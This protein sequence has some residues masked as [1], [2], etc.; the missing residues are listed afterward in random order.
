MRFLRTDK[1][2]VNV[3][4]ISIVSWDCYNPETGFTDYENENSWFLVQVRADGTDVTLINR[5]IIS[6]LEPLKDTEF[7]RTSVINQLGQLCVTSILDP[8]SKTQED[9]V[10]N[11][12]ALINQL[13]R[14][15]T[16]TLAMSEEK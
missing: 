14:V 1:T 9:I 12:D 4:Y 3:D 10:I 2:C 11:V 6:I 8:L 7:D 15:L 13:K 16:N 5:P